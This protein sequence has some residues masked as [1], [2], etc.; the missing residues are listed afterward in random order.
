MNMSKS[1]ICAYFRHVFA[2]N[3][4]GAFCQHFFSG[5]EISVKFSFF[6]PNRIFLLLLE[7]AHQT[8]L[9][10]KHVIEFN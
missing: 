1:E 4:F 7:N 2:N 9:F 5:F 8:A 10:Y 3:F 6:D